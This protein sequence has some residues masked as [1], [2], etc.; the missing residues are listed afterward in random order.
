MLLRTDQKFTH[1]HQWWKNGDHPD[2][3]SVAMEFRAEMLDEPIGTFLSEGE[4][5]RHFR[6]PDV[7][8]EVIHS[9]CGADYDAHGWIDQG[10]EGITVCPG[11]YVL[12]V[13]KGYEVVKPTMFLLGVDKIAWVADCRGAKSHRKVFDVMRDR[14][15]YVIKH[16]DDTGHIVDSYEIEK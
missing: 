4:V 15:E 6:H 13:G 16:G 8:G 12:T 9:A 2:D 14:S 7:P 11:D 3:N 10:A 5:V 1:A